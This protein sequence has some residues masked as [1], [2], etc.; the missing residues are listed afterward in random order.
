MNFNVNDNPL[1]VAPRPVRITPHLARSTY[2]KLV[3]SQVDHVKLSDD[4]ENID[5]YKQPTRVDSWVSSDKDLS[6]PRASPR[7]SL[8]SEALEEFLSICM[9]WKCPSSPVLRPRRNCA[10]S[11]PTF[12]L[13]YRSRSRVDFIHTKGDLSSITLTEENEW[14]SRA[15]SPQTLH[16]RDELE[17]FDIQ[18]FDTQRWNVAHSLSSPISRARNP[19]L[20]HP[21][22]DI[23]ISGISNFQSSP[24]ITSASPMSPAAVPLPVPT[25]DELVKVY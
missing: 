14:V 21:S 17:N 16:E 11:L 3:A 8:P 2:F 6:S 9:G 18:D 25:P 20:R 23:A 10:V 22:Y 15:R 12:G 7:S 1:L 19:F 5:E 13:P 24:P 4:T